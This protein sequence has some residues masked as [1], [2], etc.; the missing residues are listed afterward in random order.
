MVS[1]RENTLGMHRSPIVSLDAAATCAAP[2][3]GIG[4]KAAGAP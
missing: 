3:E 2:S 1:L 4:T